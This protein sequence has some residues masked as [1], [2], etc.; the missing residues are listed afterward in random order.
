MKPLF[1]TDYA[2]ILERADQIDPLE[3]GK[4]RNYI[5]GAVTYLSPYISRGVISA[6][7]VL[8]R[9][10]NNGYK[11][12]EMDSF[13]K[14]LCW[15]DYFQR[16]GQEK[17]LNLAIKQTQNLVS[18]HDISSAIVRGETGIE[19][20]DFAIEQLYQT[21]YMHNHCRM[22]T[23][24]LACNLAQS[25][26]LNPARWMYYYLLD[27]D[28]ASNTC[29]WQ[30][31]AG[32]NSNKK[33]YANQENINRFTHT[34]QS[35]TFLDRAYPDFD[36]RC[37]PPELQQTQKFEAATIL[38]APADIQLDPT[39]PTYLYNYY[40]LDPMW[41]KGE[42][43]NRVL[44][45]DPG[46]F[47]AYPVSQKCLDFVLELAKNINGLQ[48]YVGSFNQLKEQWNLKDIL[49]KEQP[50]NIGYSGM[51]EPRDWIAEEISGYFPSFFSYWKKVSKVLPAKYI[52]HDN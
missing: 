17:D 36:Q 38:P 50:L 22:F 1:P 11:I 46:F 45:L 34:E 49:Y 4:T 39:R 9:V 15:R 33:Y 30:W 35:N 10:L 7:Q 32:A 27:G 52:E 25:H 20:V 12:G 14:E 23:A 44:L 5:D 51:E 29:S 21:G 16:V 47:A 41:H 43:G 24:S 31:V 42:R 40:N 2:L 18:N 6:R 26:W 37:I 8:Q 28:W 3:Y 19:G 13:V 48:V